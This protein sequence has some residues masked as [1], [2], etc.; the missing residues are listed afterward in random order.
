MEDDFFELRGERVPGTCEWILADE[1]FVSWKDGNMS[2]SQ[3]LLMYGPPGCGK[4]V[5]ASHIISELSA[6]A[7]PS[8]ICIYSYCRHDDESKQDLVAT[9]RTA[10]FHLAERIEKY[11]GAL[12]H[13]R[14]QGDYSTD[15][16]SSLK[17]VW[18]KLFVGQLEE[19]GFSGSIKWV[20]DGL[21]ESNS[22]QRGQFVNCLSDIRFTKVDVKILIVSRY[23]D[24]IVNKLRKLGSAIVEIDI[25]RVAEDVRKV[26]Q[27]NIRNSERLSTPHITDRVTTLLESRS[28]GLFLWVRLVFE[29]LTRMTTDVEIMRC[30]ENL[31]ENLSNMYERTLGT[32]IESLPSSDLLLSKYIFQWTLAARRPLTVVELRKGLEPQFGAL[33]N[34]EYE[35]KRCCGGLVVVDGTKRVKLLHLT[36]AEFARQTSS[37]FDEEKLAH[38][39][40][41]KCC[42]DTMQPY[43]SM[44]E[45]F[46]GDN[47]EETSPLLVYSCLYWSQHIRMSCPLDP[48]LR[49]IILSFFNTPQVLTW[50]YAMFITGEHS[51]LT[52]SLEQDWGLWYPLLVFELTPE[53]VG[54]CSGLH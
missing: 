51:A 43:D 45:V 26:I 12:S 1:T 7:D 35:I 10:I 21:D 36:V 8:N 46:S 48:T 53:G 54:V 32:L 38:Q 16:M 44:S 39:A 13:F 15:D 52:Q 41:A 27:Y 37:F 47:F 14:T 2:P 4:S 28:Q 23:H 6:A 25:P 20:I 11:R 50:I 31:P 34:V 42:I 5:L 3:L 18:R 40:I 30:L 17:F 33:T 29:E 19:S 9:V 22:V 24:G 49:G